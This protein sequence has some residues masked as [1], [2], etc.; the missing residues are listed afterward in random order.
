VPAYLVRLVKDWDL[1][2]FFAADDIDDLVDAVDECT[3]VDA[4]EYVELPPAASCGQVPQSRSR[5]ICVTV[6]M[7]R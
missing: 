5:S 2:G 7:K 3:D 1:V 4:C 6:R